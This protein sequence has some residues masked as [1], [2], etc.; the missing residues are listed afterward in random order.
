MPALPAAVLFKVR[1]KR[2]EV[3]VGRMREPY[4]DTHGDII[5]KHVFGATPVSFG[6]QISTNH[7]L[8][9]D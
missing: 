8:W 3:V 2:D 4:A 1:G 7:Y 9:L 5:A 6:F